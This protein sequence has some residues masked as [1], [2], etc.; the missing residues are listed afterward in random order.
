[1]AELKRL[2]SAKLWDI[3]CYFVGESMFFCTNLAYCADK[4]GFVLLCQQEGGF[5]HWVDAI[6]L[7]GEIVSCLIVLWFGHW[8]MSME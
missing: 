1:M 3:S 4:G 5:M 8:L 6:R 2:L 7:C